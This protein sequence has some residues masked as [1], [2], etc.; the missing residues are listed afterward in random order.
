MNLKMHRKIKQI[1]SCILFFSITSIFSQ[2]ETVILD[3][4]KFRSGKYT[5]QEAS[6]KSVIVTRNTEEQVEHELISG[7]IVK[8]KI[9]WS[10]DCEYVLTQFWS[11]N[12]AV[13][14]LNGSKIYVK[15][16]QISG[17]KYKYEARQNNVISSFTMIKS[18]L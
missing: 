17:D 8:Y 12:T 14:K 6:Y 10:S 9:D 16:I 7:L 1:V 11:N 2:E 15:I 13:A 3:C 18:A 4:E 5:Y